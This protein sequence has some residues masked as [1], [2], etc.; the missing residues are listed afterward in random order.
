MFFPII[1]CF[2]NTLLL[3]KPFISKS[4]YKIVNLFFLCMILHERLV[5]TGLCL[6]LDEIHAL[7]EKYYKA[8]IRFY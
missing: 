8:F 7:A 3:C 6:S 4:Q 1:L 2:L 5:F